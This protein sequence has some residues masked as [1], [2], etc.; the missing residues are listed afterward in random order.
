[1]STK[2]LA[3]DEEKAILEKLLA[4]SQ[5]EFVAVHGR[6]R[7]GKTYLI[8]QQFEAQI[9]IEI[10]GDHNK[11]TG[12]QLE[13]FKNAMN[14]HFKKTNHVKAKHWSEAFVQLGDAVAKVKSKQ[15]KV[16]FFDEL[17]WL[18]SPKSGFLSSLGYFWNTWATKRND[19][20]L[21]VCGSAAS[22]MIKNIINNTGGLHN[23]ITQQ[24]NLQPLTLK[25][26]S[27][28]LAANNV[29]LNNYQLVQLY[30]AIGGIPEYLNYIQPGHSA[31]QS[32]EQLYFKKNGRLTYEFENLYS[33]LF[34]NSELHVA[35]ILLLA[36]HKYG[37]SRTA[38][39]T[40]L[41]LKSGKRITK[42]LFELE[43]SGFIAAKIP[44]NKTSYSTIYQLID[45]FSL[46]Y[47]KFIYQK[48]LAT[49]SWMLLAN[50]PS[51]KSWCG[52]AFE[53][54][55]TK[56]I[57]QIKNALQ[58]GGIHSYESTWQGG[59]PNATAQVDL[60]LDR[61]DNTINLFEIKYYNKPFEITKKYATELQQ[62]INIFRAETKTKKVIFCTAI[63]TYGFATNQ[64][65]IGLIDNQLL[66]DDLFSS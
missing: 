31:T 3:R 51:Y 64:Y 1:M 5:S 36:K 9:V 56:H 47:L 23:R 49:T 8:R 55:C 58:I 26:T 62:K 48:K 50:T 33:A 25:E 38:I 60:L 54:L 15:K 61:N 2:I 40:K 66:I 14:S 27:D 39:I 45:E 52:F 42:V 57:A 12:E 16:I 35:I 53:A 32:I 17:P 59:T 20:V 19:I 24:I 13:N 4:S 37:L 28:Y 21:V 10:C 46:F 7:V 22:W 43:Q 11:N 44:Y 65:S 41:A 63:S 30:M 6:R 34:E 29:K 18:D